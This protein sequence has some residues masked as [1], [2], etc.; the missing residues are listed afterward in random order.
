MTLLG[1]H[2]IFE[3]LPTSLTVKNRENKVKSECYE[4]TSL[5]E[6]K[7]GYKVCCVKILSY[8]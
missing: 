8:C 5:F 6:M 7:K 1:S 4:R 2:Y 3:L